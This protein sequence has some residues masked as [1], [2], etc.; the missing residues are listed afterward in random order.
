MGRTELHEEFQNELF[1]FIN[2]L[3]PVD[4]LRFNVYVPRID[5]NLEVAGDDKIYAM[6]QDYQKKFWLIDPMHP[7]KFDDSETIVVSNTLLMT[8]IAWMRTKIY[9][10]FFEPN[11]VF[12]NADVFF[13]RNERII[14]VLSLVRNEKHKPFT[15]REIREL[16]IIQPFVQFTLNK[17]YLPQRIHDRTT[18]AV[19]FELTPRELDVV[20]L[21]L[22][23][24]SNNILVDQLK[25]SLPTLRT[26]LQNIY[27]KVGVHSNSELISKIL[28]KLV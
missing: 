13:R 22:T 4:G 7:S 20:E 23:G 28:G 14:A 3:L 1:Q 21:S 17:T 26:H 16:E 24:A 2:R 25:I 8:N 9:Q 18:L 6:T 11:G 19:E 12:H 27:A 15:P 10:E 5:L